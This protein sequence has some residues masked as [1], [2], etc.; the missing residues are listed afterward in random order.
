MRRRLVAALAVY[1][2]AFRE[3]DAPKISAHPR[4]MGGGRAARPRSG[5]AARP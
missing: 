3:V 4:A 1:E 5:H 2:V